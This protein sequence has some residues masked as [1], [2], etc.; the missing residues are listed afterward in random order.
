[1]RFLK[2]VSLLMLWGELFAQ[3]RGVA[4]IAHRGEHLSHPENTLPAFQAALDAGADYFEVDVRTSADGRL[5]LMHDATVERTTN[6]KGRVA[7]MTFAQIRALRAGG[8]AVPEFE[9]A[10]K[11]ARGRGQVYVDCKQV[12]VEDLIGALERQE[13]LRQVVVYGGFEFLRQVQAR[14]PGVRIMPEAG[15]LAGV[16]R[17]VDELK[18]PVI[19]FDARDW[20]AEIIA[21]ARQSGAEIFV[22]RLGPA[23]TVEAWQAAIEAGATGI[24]TDHPARLVEFLKSQGLRR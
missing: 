3:S 2:V 16:R 24:Q 6:G 8:A 10:L 4:V 12:S 11:L 5:V 20:Q 19:A 15:S 23:D 14:R 13:M 22:D 9:E 21:V 18:P 17:I 1:M 7:E